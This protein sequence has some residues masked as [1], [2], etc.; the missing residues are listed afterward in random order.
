MPTWNGVLIAW[1]YSWMVTVMRSC[2]LVCVANTMSL[3]AMARSKPLWIRSGVVVTLSPV[4]AS[5]IWFRGSIVAWS[6]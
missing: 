4:V 3:V 1:P 6:R 5:S 2:P